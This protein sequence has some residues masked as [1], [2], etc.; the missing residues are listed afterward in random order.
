MSRFVGFPDGALA[1][2]PIPNLFFAR[3]LPEIDS[4]AELKL[5]LHVLWRTSPGPR[6]I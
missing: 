1:A 2:T 4:L 6:E 3:V 5:T